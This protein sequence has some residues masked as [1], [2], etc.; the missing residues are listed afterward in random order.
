MINTKVNNRA[1]SYII[2]DII[3]KKNGRRKK[4]QY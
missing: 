3:V 2:I 1:I 4:R